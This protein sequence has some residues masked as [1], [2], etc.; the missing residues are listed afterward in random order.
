MA[1]ALTAFYG[2]C[3]VGEVLKAAT[4][5]L[6][7]PRGLLDPSGGRAYLVIESPKAGR[8]GI[9]VVQHATIACPQVINYLDCFFG[10]L[11]PDAPLYPF[12]A[13]CFRAR[14]D[15]VTAALRLTR[16]QFLPGGLRGGGAIAQYM[17]DVPIATLLWRMRIKQITTLSHY[18]QEVTAAVS[19]VDLDETDRLHIAVL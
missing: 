4:R 16:K 18:I 5:H 1:C 7:L 2:P 11:P 14:F 8:R 9:G 15:Q 17:D 19:L 12:S 3:R 10:D 6:V 13:L